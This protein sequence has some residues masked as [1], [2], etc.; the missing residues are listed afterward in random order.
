MSATLTPSPTTEADRPA[1]ESGTAPRAAD[2]GTYTKTMSRRSS[3]TTSRATGGTAGRARVV[4]TSSSTRLGVG[5]AS[6]AAA[7]MHPAFAR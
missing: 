3:C 5:M 1:G 7:S 4:E 6:R 2:L